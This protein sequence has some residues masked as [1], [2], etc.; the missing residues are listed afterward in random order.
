MIMIYVVSL[1]QWLRRKLIE[2][3]WNKNNNYIMLTILSK[4]NEMKRRVRKIYP[5][6]ELKL[7][8]LVNQCIHFASKNLV[9]VKTLL[10][11][12]KKVTRTRTPEY[13]V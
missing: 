11:L 8:F 6:N 12:N 3:E 1:P 2:T 4:L 13:L 5:K 9:K 7:S 10:R